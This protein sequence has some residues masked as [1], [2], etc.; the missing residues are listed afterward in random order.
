MA[1]TW[2]AVN[3]PALLIVVAVEFSLQVAEVLTT[4]VLLS[5]KRAV[6]EQLP[7]VPSLSVDGHDT[8]TL[9]SVLA[10]AGVWK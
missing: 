9:L 4:C 6:A 1:V 7:E 2:P 3:T 8:A 10:G 5:L